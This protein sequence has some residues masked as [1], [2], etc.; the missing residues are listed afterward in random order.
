MKAYY[1]LIPV[2]VFLLASCTKGNETNEQKEATSITLEAGEIAF[3]Q[4]TLH[5]KATIKEELQFK[6]SVGFEYS[7]DSSFPEGSTVE[8]IA[9]TVNDDYSFALTIGPLEPQTLYY[10][11]SF[12]K[13]TK[14]TE[15]S[16]GE[17]KSFTTLK[18]ETSID[19]TTA[20]IGMQTGLF[21][22]VPSITTEE[23][24]FVFNLGTSPE[25]LVRKYGSLYWPGDDASKLQYSINDLLPDTEYYYSATLTYKGKEYNSE[26]KSFKTLD[27]TS[28]GDFADLGLSVKWSLTNVGASSPEKAGGYYAWGETEEKESYTW[29]NYKYYDNTEG[30]ITKYTAREAWTYNY[31]DGL[32]AL[33]ATDDV[34]HLVMGD[35][36]RMPTAAEVSELIFA[37]TSN[38]HSTY[39]GQYG[40]FIYND[41]GCIFFPMV[42]YKDGDKLF[43][44]GPDSYYGDDR[45]A[46]CVYYWSGSLYDVNPWRNQ[47]AMGYGFGGGFTEMNTKHRYLGYQIRAVR[48]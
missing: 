17:T 22:I 18:D 11:R 43:I 48:P 23:V 14:P 2:F 26:V 25:S 4:A 44:E 46:L 47:Y 16:Y 10:Y 36:W 6:Y 29:D 42:G 20:E 30:T 35:S 3:N 27:L 13:K 31:G 24:Y 19:V 39:K 40:V 45:T 1:F 38:V 21:N 33:E 7:T 5:G 15:Y 9:S 37:E 41:K 8:K 34:A 32:F 12:A 28:Q